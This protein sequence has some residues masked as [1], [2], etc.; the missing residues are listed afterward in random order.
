MKGFYIFEESINQLQKKQTI[1][2][3]NLGDISHIFNTKLEPNAMV[4]AEVEITASVGNTI[5]RATTNE[6]DTYDFETGALIALMKM[7][8]KEK[9]LKAVE[10]LYSLMEPRGAD[11]DGDILESKVEHMAKKNA[12]LLGENSRLNYIKSCN[13]STIESLENTRDLLINKNNELIEEN[14]KLKSDKDKSWKNYQRKIQKKQDRINQLEAQ[15]KASE[16]DKLKNIEYYEKEIKELKDEVRLKND[17]INEWKQAH[18]RQN[19]KIGD[20]V[21]E[22]YKLK[23]DCEKLQHGY[24]DTDMIFCGGRQNGKQFTF[25]V[26]LFKKIDQKKVDAAYEEAYGKRLRE[27]KKK[28]ELSGTFKIDH[29]FMITGWDPEKDFVSQMDKILGFCKPFTKREE[30]W[31]KILGDYKDGESLRVKVERAFIND[32]LSEAEEN[33]L[34]WANGGEKPTEWD[35]WESWRRH[36]YIVFRVWY[37]GKTKELTWGYPSDEKTINYLP[38][39]RWDLFK[40]GRLAVKVNY[41]NYKEFYEA[42]EKELGKKPMTVYTGEYTVSICKKDGLFEVFTIEDQKKTGRKIVNWEDVR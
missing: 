7:C 20:L 23:L 17:A 32:F 10:E 27:F 6:D 13:E 2:C 21:C 16:D 14:E 19:T 30:M 31:G 33:G 25:L 11:L 18:S 36:D 41:Y 12:E 22:N 26:D 1:A 15:I 24:I 35:K 29:G 37:R 34:V 8:G 28:T 40:K 9:A 39:M 3:F 5:T 42:C 4:S 38:P